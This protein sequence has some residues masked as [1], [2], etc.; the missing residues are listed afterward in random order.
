M[1]LGFLFRL[2][3]GAAAAAA[4]N[5]DINDLAADIPPSGEAAMASRA[6][7]RAASLEGD[8]HRLEASV[9]KSLLINEALWELLR[10]NTKIT[11]DDLYKKIYEVDMRDGRADNKNQRAAVECPYCKH[12]VAPR[13]PACLYCGQVID[14]SAFSL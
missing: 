13:H 3:G 6:Q 9:A 7:S 11:D 8:V 12:M 4:A 2:I 5:N 14:S 10:E 1:G